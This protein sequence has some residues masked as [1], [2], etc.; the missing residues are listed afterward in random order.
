M[1]TRPPVHRPAGA[2]STAERRA[3]YDAA[4][5][6]PSRIY[7]RRWQALRRAYLAAHPLCECGCGYAAAV[8]DH[9]RA[10]NGDRG[11]LYDWSNLQALTKA[12]HDRKTAARDGGFGNPLVFIS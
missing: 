3:A 5:V 1:P 11:L 2:R 9:R 12:C 8:V 10:H 7:G 4:R 6:S